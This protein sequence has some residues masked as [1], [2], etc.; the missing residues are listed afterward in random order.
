MADGGELLKIVLLVICLL[1]SALF[2]GSE[3][4]FLSL[5]RLRLMHLVRNGR[6]GA[7]RVA[8]MRERPDRFLSTVLLGNNLVNTA[9]AALGTAV[10]ISFLKDTAQ[11]LLASTIGV[12]LLLLVFGETVPKSVA[13]RHAERVSF[14]TVSIIEALEILLFPFTRA[15]Q[16]FT[17]AV[18]RLTRGETVSRV[19]EEE[20]R[21]LIS[22]GKE[23]G[24]VET[25]EA[26]MLEKVFHFGDRAVREL[27]TPRTELVSVEQGTTLREFLSIYTQHSHT[28]FPVYEGN[29][30]NL[31]GILSVKDMVRALGEGD[32][33]PTDSVTKLLRPTYFVPETKPVAQLF[34]ELRSRG[35][36]MAIVIDEYGGVA[37]LV[38]LKQL[39]ETVV[40]PV[41]EE[42]EPL[43]EEY[44]VVDENTYRM[45][46][47]ISIQEANEKMELGLPEGDYQTVAGFVLERLG[48]IPQEGESFLYGDLRV[49]VRRMSGVRIETVE[50][51]RTARQGQGR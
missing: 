30:D 16:W 4:A 29:V 26:E 36:Q 17:Q 13:T 42:G 14:S 8:R 35:Q 38:T 2:S 43:E 37:G 27:M 12:T 23:E 15:L 49:R 22:A 28:R 21:T 47:G 3:A 9:A 44:L 6:P 19:T 33:K 39:L 51:R 18:A 34:F 24:A 50:V 45:E 1:L 46:G 11:A 7:A 40:G 5:Q 41:G 20:I 31:I 48:H 10:A 32:L 25:A